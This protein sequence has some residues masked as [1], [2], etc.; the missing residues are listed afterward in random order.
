MH[1]GIT[2]Y[3]DPFTAGKLAAVANEFPDIWSDQ[4]IVNIPE[5]EQMPIPL[6]SDTDPKPSRVYPLREKDRDVVNI[7]FD[8]LYDKEKMVQTNYLTRFSYPVFVVWRD[9]PKG[10][11]GR[12]IV[13]IRN[14]NKITE[15][16][17]YPMPLQ[18]DIV[19]VIAGYKY[20]TVIDTSGYFYQFRVKLDNRHKLIVVSYKGQEQFN[21]AIIGYKGLLPYIQR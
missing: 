3:G 14:L 15:S 7:T 4:G 12:V 19:A 10:R 18:A 6:K 5:D 11:K 17:T 9:I 13:D 20:I 1:N 8:N 16:D 21:I 2:I